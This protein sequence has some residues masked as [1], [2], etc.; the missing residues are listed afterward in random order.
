MTN[1]EIDA[2]GGLNEEEVRRR[3]I[4]PK[5]LVVG[6]VAGL[7]ASA[8]RLILNWSEDQRMERMSHFHGIPAL[9]LWMLLGALG[10]GLGL[11]MVRRLAPEAAGSGIP[12]LQM[13]V[14]GQKTL[15]W[16][17]L[18]PVKFVAGVL[19]IGSG[20]TLGREGPTIQMGGASGLMVANWFRVKPG[21]GERKALISAGAGAGLAA[22]FNSPLAGLIFVLEELQGNFTP[23]VFVAAF[24]ASVSADVVSRLLVGEKPVFDLEA[25]SSGSGAYELPFALLLGLFAGGLG[26]L[27]NRSLLGSLD[28]FDRFTKSKW[29]GGALAGMVAGIAGWYMPHLSGSG[30]ALADQAIAGHIAI[31]VLPA[32]LIARFFLTMVCY[33]CGTAGGIFAP[34]LVIGALGGLLFGH[35]ANHFF[36]GW[37]PHPETF[38]VLGMG[39]LFTAVVRAP[40][41]GIV[42]M[43]EMTGKYHFMLPLLVC[44]LA[45]YGV[46]EMTG[47]PPIYD[48]LRR[49]SAALAPAT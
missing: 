8:F 40:L 2:G 41:T 3:H 19:G 15:N 49:R 37:I 28:G 9:L 31:A 11:W 46:V 25:V 30:G 26:I 20:M 45:A 36:P 1:G 4:L 13:V 16:R 24:L 33:G 35:G 38:A 44:C 10:G 18:L 6:I 5:A 22:A 21:G 7:I 47:C 48:A 27:F 32:L 39:A 42:L 12:H 43:V 29:L 14:Q 34:M 17:R 23:V